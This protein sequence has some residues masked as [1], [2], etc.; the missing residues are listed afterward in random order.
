MPRPSRRPIL[1]A[2]ELSARLADPRL[3]LA[4]VRWFLG[5]PAMPD[6]VLSVGGRFGYVDNGETP[7][8]QAI[9]FDYPEAPLLF[10]V[11]GLPISS[12]IDGMDNFKGIRIGVVV[13]CE[14][15]YFAGGGAG[16]W[17]YD[18]DGERIRSFKG[19]D[20]ATHAQNFLD[21]IR[22]REPKM[23]N[24][25]I[26][27]AHISSALC[28]LGNISQRL[29][30]TMPV[31]LINERIQGDALLSDAYGRMLEHCGSNGVDFGLTP[32]ALGAGLTVDRVKECFEGE[33]SA[34]ANQWISRDYRKGF[35][36]PDLG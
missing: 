2:A 28:H 7:N 14:N 22:T 13:E 30:Q 35:V 1:T 12:A 4:D 18:N 6:R 33:F 23:V 36:V 32:A 21:A 27:G 16:G 5:D 26:E 29:G 11:R 24:G 34:E 15:G 8:T 3:R 9:L 31:G 20:G 17:A 10:E 25:R 19:D